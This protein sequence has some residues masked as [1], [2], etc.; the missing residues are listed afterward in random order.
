[1]G[2]EDSAAD[3]ALERLEG[4]EAVARRLQQFPGRAMVNLTLADRI[5]RRFDGYRGDNQVGPALFDKDPTEVI[6]MK[7]LHSDTDQTF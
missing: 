4:L 6:G 5:I 7:A 3:L 2:G 1:L